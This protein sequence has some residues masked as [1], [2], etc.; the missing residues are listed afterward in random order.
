MAMLNNQMVYIYICRFDCTWSWLTEKDSALCILKGI[1]VGFSFVSWRSW[2]SEKMWN[3]NWL[4]SHG[5]CMQHLCTF[6]PGCPDGHNNR[7]FFSSTVECD[8]WATASAH[9]SCFYSGMFFDKMEP[10]FLSSLCALHPDRHLNPRHQCARLK[11]P[12]LHTHR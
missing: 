1:E 4:Q 5:G 12:V 6:V 2:W 11:E 7:A 10:S 3:V 9:S 8:S